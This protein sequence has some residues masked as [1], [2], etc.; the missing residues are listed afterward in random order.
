M[1]RHNRDGRGTDQ[2]GVDYDI[3]Y[4]PDWMQQ[5]KVTRTLENGR[6]STK[7]LFRNPGRPARAPGPRVRTRVTSKDRRI[8]FEIGVDDPHGVITRIVIETSPTG[9]PGDQANV[10]FT[11]DDGVKGK[12]AKR[13]PR[14]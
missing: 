2:R 7:T 12:P 14:R 5:I 9:R 10:V 13:T 8:D 4:Q 6:Q 3:S 11:I 1:A